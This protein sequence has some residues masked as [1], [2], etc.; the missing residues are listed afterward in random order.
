MTD[1][2]ETDRITLSDNSKNQ[3][4]PMA[5]TQDTVEKAAQKVDGAQDTKRESGEKGMFV[6][7]IVE[8]AIMGAGGTNSPSQQ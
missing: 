1:V 7:P 8:F 3:E 5:E 4:T 6:L 2:L